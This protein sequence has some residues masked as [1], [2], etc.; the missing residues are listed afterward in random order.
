M[1]GVTVVE[2]WIKE[3]D[4]DKS[5]ALGMNELPDGTWFIGAKVED[6]SVWNDIK[7]GKVRGF[8]I[9]G[10]FSEVNVSMAECNTNEKLFLAEIEKLFASV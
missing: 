5:I 1:N 8:S 10:Y 2:S 6:D 9:E 4:A 3:G 7:A